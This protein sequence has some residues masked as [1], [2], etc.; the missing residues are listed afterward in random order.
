[1]SANL[2]RD[3][4]LNS[5][6]NQTGRQTD[7]LIN[8]ETNQPTRRVNVYFEMK[9]NAMFQVPIYQAAFNLSETLGPS[10]TETVAWFAASARGS[11]NLWR[12]QNIAIILSTRVNQYISILLDKEAAMEKS[13]GMTIR[14]GTEKTVI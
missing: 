5:P 4:Q 9:W 1:M 13:R 8:Q 11:L 6:T 12:N 2:L 3:R 7:R 10:G 14:V